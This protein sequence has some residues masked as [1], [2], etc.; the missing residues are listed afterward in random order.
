MPVRTLA[1]P[2]AFNQSVQISCIKA[3]ISVDQGFKPHMCHI[4]K[5]AA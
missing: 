5:T 4:L 3:Q 1:P 2:F